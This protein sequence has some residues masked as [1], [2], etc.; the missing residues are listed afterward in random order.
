M[1][2][3]REASIRE[4]G[5]SPRAEELHP[6]RGA[7]H[8]VNHVYPCLNLFPVIVDSLYPRSEALQITTIPL[9]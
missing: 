2:S 9:Y 8:P 4:P 3:M 6:L 5:V 1:A 7:E